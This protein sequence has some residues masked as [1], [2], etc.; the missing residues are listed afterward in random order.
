MTKRRFMLLALLVAA[1][2]FLAAGCGDDDDEASSTGGATTEEGGGEAVSGN[3]SV[4][5]VWTGA[6]GEAFQAVLDGFTEANPDVKVSYKSAKEP[7]TV[8]STSVEGGNPPDI[9]ALPQPGSMI[10]FAERGALKPIDFAEATIKEG[11]SDSWL[12]L[13]TVEGKLYGLFF[14][15]ANKSTVWYNVAAFEDAGVEAPADWDAFLEAGDT[16]KASGVTPYSIGAADGWT[17]TD[18]FENI[19]LRVAGGEKYDQLTK[20]EIP[21]TDQSVKDALTEMGKVLQPDNIAGG[22]SSALQTDFP[23]SVTQIFSDPP[24]AA[25]VMEGDFVGGV[26]AA[27]TQAKPEEGFNVY[28]FPEINDSGPVVVGGGDVI[29]MFKDNPAARAL[30]EY[31]ASP[32]AAEI[33]AAKGGFSSPNKNVDPESYPDEL[34]KTTATE[35]ANADTFRFDMSDLMPSEF[36]SDALFTLLQD[37]VKA[38]DDVDGMADKLEKAAAAAFK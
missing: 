1:L 22:A 14:K 37:F 12:D 4:L 26:I 24:K 18:L 8:L 11:Y 35:L 17:L 5:A 28:A 27:E 3:I 31:L 36:G 15:G 32:E 33:W 7:A 23:T 21:W 30:I 25:Q 16:L 10:E 13:G 34:T 29:V 9:A 19:Y 2:A 38:P 20:H 6:E